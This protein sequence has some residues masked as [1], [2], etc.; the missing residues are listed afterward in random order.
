MN[1]LNRYALSAALGLVLVVNGLALVGV[2]YN[3]AGK[4]DSRLELSQREL[5][6]DYSDFG[7]SGENSGLG[8]RLDWRTPRDADEQEILLDRAV[9][10]E[11]GL[12]LEGQEGHYDTHESST[13]AVLELDGPAWKAELDRAEARLKDATKALARK[14]NEENTAL[15]ATYRSQFEYERD[16]ASR[17][18]VVAAGSDAEALRQRYPDRKR[19]ALVKARLY[20]WYDHNQTPPRLQA[21]V[22]RL[23]VDAL[24]VPYRWRQQVEERLVGAYD[25]PIKPMRLKVAY[26]KRLEPWIEDVSLLR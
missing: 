12:P 19:Y 7:W 6:R 24:Q 21:R 1:S 23:E 18:F 16:R 4:P 8:L 25:E 17:L 22:S 9:L 14:R 20:A 5:S 13:Y 26:G 10:E 11:I 3:R 15:E 2:W